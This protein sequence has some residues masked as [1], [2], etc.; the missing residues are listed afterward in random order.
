MQLVDRALATAGPRPNCLE[1]FSAD[2]YYSCRI[3]T[4]APRAR[5]SGVDLDPAEIRRAETISRR[6]ALDDVTFRVG[7]ARTFAEQADETYD[8]VLCA[9]GLY[10]L[11]DPARLLQA[12]KRAVRGHLVLQSV[13]TLETED[14]GYLAATREGPTAWLP[15]HPRVAPRAARTARLAHRGP[16]ARRAARQ[17]PPSRSRVEF[18]SVPPSAGRGKASALRRG[19]ATA[20]RRISAMR[21]AL[22]SSTSTTS[23]GPP[24]SSSSTLRTRLRRW[25]STS[26]SLLRVIIVPFYSAHGPSMVLSRSLDR[27][28]SAAADQE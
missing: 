24:G 20:S 12:L 28:Q 16:G 8:L 13:V 3:K 22:P 6:L 19:A 26:A 10:H 5:I 1:L 11:S 18:L 15:V 17:S 2:G 25:G 21:T 27:P 14:P 7:D 9:G 4:L 23:C